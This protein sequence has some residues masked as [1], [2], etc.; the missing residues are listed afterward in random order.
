MYQ[1]TLNVIRTTDNHFYALCNCTQTDTGAT[2]L[3]FNRGANVKDIF[4][5]KLFSSYIRSTFYDSQ[6]YAKDEGF[7]L[8]HIA[9]DI[10]EKRRSMISLSLTFSI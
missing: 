6:E 10:I 3:V 8:I 1:L 4:N 2:N 9:E 7:R 5:L